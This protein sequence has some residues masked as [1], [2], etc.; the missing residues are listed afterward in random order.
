MKI[1][2]VVPESES[3]VTVYFD[4]NYSLTVDLKGESRGAGYAQQ[5]SVSGDSQRPFGCKIIQFASRSSK[6]NVSELPRIILHDLVEKSQTEAEINYIAYHDQLTS[7]YNRAYIEKIIFELEQTNNTVLSLIMI[8]MNGLKL[9]ND[10]FGHAQGDRLLA[11]MGQVLLKVC[12]QTDFIARWGGDEFLVL[13]PQTGSVACEQVCKRIREACEQE[14]DL[15]VRLSAAIGA[16]TSESGKGIAKLFVV[17]ENRMYSDKLAQSRDVRVNLI[18]DMEHKLHHWCFEN[19]G[20]SERIQDLAIAFAAFLGKD[21]AP[22]EVKLLKQLAAL[23]DIGKVAISGEI[24]GKRAPLTSDEWEVVQR[25]GEIGY[26]MAQ[27]VG[28][29]KLAE[30]VLAIHERWD[31]TGYPAKAAG[32]QIPFLARMFAL[33]DVYD[34]LTHERPY[35][36]IKTQQEALNEI[37]AGKGSQFDPA[38]TDRFLEFIA[39]YCPD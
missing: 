29:P 25:H 7:L 33:V 5:E 36:K 19:L 4:N 34:V 27:A 38:L 24:L 26:R 13:L 28:E 16:A 20:H 9:T 1:L 14:G 15:S 11:A 8:D 6:T 31:G 12:R 3:C 37:K 23:H 39:G 10:V 21:S 17:A 22:A 2:Q 30:V 35:G 32:E 18:A